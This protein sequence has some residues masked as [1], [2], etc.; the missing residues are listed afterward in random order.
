MP[1]GRGRGLIDVRGRNGWSRDA[2]R[3]GEVV[4]VELTACHAR[5]VDDVNG[6]RVREG[7]VVGFVVRGP[8]GGATRLRRP[9]LGGHITQMEPLPRSGAELA[10]HHSTTRRCELV[11]TGSFHPEVDTRERGRLKSYGAVR[12][13]TFV[14]PLPW[15][16]AVGTV[17]DTCTAVS[18]RSHAATVHAEVDVG[19]H[20][21]S[22]RYR[23][24]GLRLYFEGFER[25]Y[26]RL[27]VDGATPIRVRRS[28]A[29]S[30]HPQ[31]HRGKRR[32][33]DRLHRAPDVVIS[34]CE[35]AEVSSKSMPGTRR[36][37][38]ARS[39]RPPRSHR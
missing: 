23:P 12:L 6:G 15:P 9:G 28:H 29:G 5:H 21:R 18:C 17:H 27:A 39:A 34:G 1:S 16:Y 22:Q 26:P 19:E 3:C 32:R 11:D 38:P 20:G 30:V 31:V 8:E 37:R 25:G 13:W 10:V 33:L 36:G 4:R 35:F 7:E 14:E 24:V 2:C